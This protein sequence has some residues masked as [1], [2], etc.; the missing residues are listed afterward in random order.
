[1]TRSL[2][3]LVLCL[4]LTVPAAADHHEGEADGV[5]TLF[6]GES[7]E[8]WEGDERFWRVE[9]GAIV[10]QTTTDNAAEQNTFL[11]YRGGEFDD[12]VLSLEYQVE[13]FNSGVQYRSR[14]VGEP[15]AF[16]VAGMQCDFE[17]RWHEADEARVDKFS[18]MVFEEQG[19]M[20][21][22]QRGQM[23]RV[24]AGDDPK[25]PAITQ[26]ASLGEAAELETLVDRDGWTSLQVVAD[27]HSLTH[28]LGGRVVAAAIDD[29]P[30]AATSGLIALQLHSGPPMTIRVRNITVRPLHGDDD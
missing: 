24:T 9:E 15:E 12:F 19:R 18:G 11:I 29:D 22:A 28:C 4:S 1:M 2:A 7:L 10:G 16:S 21:L 8:G 6:D 25:K 3:S 5:V 17:A 27:G 30:A 14:Q 23:V 13:G 26:L 20:F